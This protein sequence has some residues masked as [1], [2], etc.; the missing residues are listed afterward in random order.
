MFG[1]NTGSFNLADAGKYYCDDNPANGSYDVATESLMTP[2]GTKETSS[3]PSGWPKDECAATVRPVT[4]APVNFSSLYDFGSLAEF[5]KQVD[6]SMA[7][8]MRDCAECHVGGGAHEFIITDPTANLLPPDPRQPLRSFDSSAWN[9]GYNT[10]NYFIDQYDEDNDGIIGEVLPQNY[11][12]TGVL[13][14][15][16]FMCHLEGYD[17]EARKDAIR[18]GKFD[19]SRPAGA[20]FLVPPYD[21]CSNDAN[22]QCTDAAVDCVQPTFRCEKDPTGAVIP[23]CVNDTDCFIL[24]PTQVCAGDTITPCTTGQDCI[25]AGVAGPCT[26]TF[27]DYGP[28]DYLLPTCV[29]SAGP[30]IIDGT[31]VTYNSADDQSAP[32]QEFDPGSGP[33]LILSSDVLSRLDEVPSG[34]N[35]S[36]CHFVE[37]QAD[38]KKRGASWPSDAHFESLGEAGRD[39]EVHRYAGYSCVDCHSPVAANNNAPYEAGADASDVTDSQVDENLM[40]KRGNPISGYTWTGIADTTLGHDVAKAEVPYGTLWNALDNTMYRCRTCHI[41]R[42]YPSALKT[43]FE[44]DIDGNIIYGPHN[45]AG[46]GQPEPVRK[47]G[48]VPPDP[49]V[50]GGA[51]EIY[52]LL[53]NYI[54]SGRDGGGSPGV[55]GPDGVFVGNANHIDVMACDACHTRKLG[56]GVDSQTGLNYGTGAAMV[57]LT[58]VDDEGRLFDAE[59]INIQRTIED[60][61]VRA[62]QYDSK[63]DKHIMT[64]KHGLIS[65]FWRDVDENPANPDDASFVDINAD[66]Q[67]GFMDPVKQIDVGAAM[68]HYSGGP[69]QNL[70]HDGVITQGEID[71]QRAALEEYLTAIGIDPTSSAQLR[72]SFQGI[73]FRSN[74]GT[75]PKEY[76]WGHGGCL[77]CHLD[78]AGFYNGDYELKGET[79]TLGWDNTGEQYVEPFFNVNNADYDNSTGGTPDPTDPNDYQQTDFDPLLMPKGLIGRT[80]AVQVA[81]GTTNT[82]R[83]VDRS[84]LL[85]EADSTVAGGPGP[86]TMVSGDIHGTRADIVNHLNNALEITFTNFNLADHQGFMSFADTCLVCHEDLVPPIDAPTGF[87]SR[88][89]P[90]HM[91][92]KEYDGSNTLTCT[93]CHESSGFGVKTT[94]TVT[95]DWLDWV[96]GLDNNPSTESDGLPDTDTFSPQPVF[97]EPGC[98]EWAID[99][100]DGIPGTADDYVCVEEV[101]GVETG[102][103]TCATLC[104][105][106]VEAQPGVCNDNGADCTSNDVSTCGTPA[107]AFCVTEFSNGAVTAYLSALPSP[108]TDRVVSLDASRSS[109]EGASGCSFV[110][111]P[112]DCTVIG[113]NGAE[114]VV[115]SCPDVTPRTFSAVVTDID[116]GDIARA[117]AV[118]TPT[119]VEVPVPIQDIN[120]ANNGDGTCTASATDVGIAVRARIYWGDRTSTTVTDPA[121]ELAVPGIT[122]SCGTTVRVVLYDVNYNI[123]EFTL[124]P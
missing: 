117:I 21:V 97:T 102:Y 48:P 86:R 107:T 58:G 10:Y 121:A 104:H 5:R 24:V 76:A 106:Q 39:T 6:N 63:L 20:G 87:D 101:P 122:H 57:D 19:A 66:G 100:A 62:W 13:E 1:N 7:G 11:S 79:L 2:F 44:E 3:D 96:K 52:G 45:D 95:N 85:Y 120:V 56:A 54:Q 47:P 111:D 64:I 60:N 55:V 4:Q 84:E 103:H 15:D 17:W 69:L 80:L 75:S 119:I 81:S 12:D 71:T 43:Q 8:M 113:G 70:T 41:D 92:I 68:K 22:T 109:C 77:D 61:L 78:G 98:N 105:P 27:P 35:C 49:N 36:S 94:I 51:H 18:T 31:N 14:V 112:L 38:W 30:P 53:Y 124:T 88:H 90:T 73:L 59:N 42:I 28:C 29:G 93:D 37:F 32:L 110:F 114:V 23:S 123:T 74:H 108:D 34:D 91:R 72:L 89:H 46:V 65:M 33:V 26:T 99:N 115:V 50:P 118:A 67:S 16:C 25:D 83:N 9:V 116:S 40:D 82:L